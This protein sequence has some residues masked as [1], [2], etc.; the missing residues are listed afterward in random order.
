MGGEFSR[1]TEEKPLKIESAA[2]LPLSLSQIG[3]R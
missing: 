3:E 1:E 2:T